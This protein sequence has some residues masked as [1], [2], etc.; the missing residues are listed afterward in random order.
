M[1]IVLLLFLFAGLLLQP[2]MAQNWSCNRAPLC[3]AMSSCAEADFY[4]RVCGHSERDGDNDGIPCE[5]LCGDTH[6]IYES[7]RSAND[8]GGF[9]LVSP[10]PAFSCTVRK[11]CSQMLSCAEAQYHLRQCGNVSLDRDG[12]GIPCNAVCR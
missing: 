1:R 8:A 11:T 5:A 4:F 12:D 7:R 10:A 3:S 2:A 9:G 6:E